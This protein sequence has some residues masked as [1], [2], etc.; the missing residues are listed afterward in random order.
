[1]LLFFIA[2]VFIIPRA[3]FYFQKPEIGKDKAFDNWVAEMN[4]KD[5]VLALENVSIKKKDIQTKQENKLFK[6][7]PNTVNYQ[8]MKQLGFDGKTANILLKYRKKGAKFYSKKDLLR[9][10]G[11][12]EDLY[13]KLENYIIFPK[14]KKKSFSDNKS[15]DKKYQ[16]EEF[17]VK[18]F[19]FDPNTVSYKEMRKLGIDGKTAN[20]LLKYRGNK[21]VFYEKEDLLKV[22][23]FT[24]E[25]YTDLENYIIFPQKKNRSEANKNNTNKTIENLEIELNAATADELKQLK[26]IGKYIS[27]EIVDYRDKLG[28]FY[29]K[30]QLKEVYGITNKVFENISSSIIIDKTLIVKIDINKASFKEL[31]SHPYIDETITM[32]ILKLRK[33]LSGFNKVEDLI[34]YDNLSQEEFENLKNYFK[35]SD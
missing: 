13:D 27:K 15:V 11:F 21:T 20:I 9:I 14:N 18:Y 35:I 33:E 23:G 32:K 31:I 34:Y 17:T 2:I 28:G 12:E 26:G 25:L 1:M 7:D 30:N 22:Y 6:F 5:S 10:Y 16:K 8:E 3:Y 24:E 19:P 4:T 29:S